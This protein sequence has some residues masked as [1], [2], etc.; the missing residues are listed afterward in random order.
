MKKLEKK[1]LCVPIILLLLFLV[2]K[3]TEKTQIVN[4]FPFDRTNDLSSYMGNLYFLHEYG[5]HEF[6]P[7]WYNGRYKLFEVYPPAW[8]Y[9]TYPFYLITGSIEGAA[10]LSIISILV[11]GSLVCLYLGRRLGLNLLERTAFFALIFA[12]PIAVGNFIRL[13]RPHELFAW[14]AFAA[15]FLILLEYRDKKIDKRILFA[16]IPYSLVLLSHTGVFILASTLFLCLFLTHKLKEWKYIILSGLVTAFITSFWWVGFLKGLAKGSVLADVYS[17]AYRLLSLK[18]DYL[19]ENITSLISPLAFL[20]LFYLYYKTNKNRRELWFF[21]PQI[22]IATAFLTRLVIA[23]PIFNRIYPDIYNMFFIINSAYLIFK[24]DYGKLNKVWNRLVLGGLI[25][26]PVL[27]IVAYLILIPGFVHHT[28]E[29]KE[30]LELLEQVEGKFLILNSSSLAQ[31]FYTY[32]AVYHNLSTPFGWSDP[33]VPADYVNRLY[34]VQTLAEKNNCKEFVDELKYFNTTSV[35]TY[36]EY[37]E[38]LKICR[39]KEKIKK[40]H[41]CLYLVK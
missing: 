10:I 11:I 19:V 8:Y 20:V 9:F 23:I 2:V 21:L 35:I 26:F 33:S 18:S 37:C 29:D 17:F 16:V 1:W 38:V 40:E 27:S 31:A 5:Y 28:Q 41:S 30:T 34:R 7:N 24:I 22:L 6:V 15:L 39:L 13:G 12:N 14:T 25:V 32:G 3:L 36:R 4:E